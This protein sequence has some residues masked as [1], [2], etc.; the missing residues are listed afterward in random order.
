MNRSRLELEPG[1]FL[2]ARRAVWLAAE[3]ALLVSDLHLGYTWTHRHA[4]Q[5]LPLG[6][7][8][9]AVPR[10]LALVEEYAPDEV[11]LLGDILHGFAPVEE[12][13]AELEELIAGIG[14]ACRLR[15]IEGNHDF[16]LHRALQRLGVT[17]PLES[18]VALGGHFLL[19]GHAPGNLQATALLGGAVERG[20]RVIFG[21]EH[22]AV[23]LSDGIAS[24]ARCPCFIAAEGALVLPCFTAWSPGGGGGRD[25]FSPLG[26]ALQIRHRIAILAGKLLPLP[27]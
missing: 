17:L 23:H 18:H 19:H 5:L 25:L 27:A 21:H 7:S 20:G 4:G 8:D 10:L 24:R 12:A 13:L 6:V 26:Q 16:A 3:R 1:L 22:P 15:L 2:D 9:D 14:R 11:L